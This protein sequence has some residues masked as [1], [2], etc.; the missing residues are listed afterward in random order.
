MG[1]LFI[2]LV[3]NIWHELHEGCPICFNDDGDW[4]RGIGGD[5]SLCSSS[6]LFDHSASRSLLLI[7]VVIVA[8]GIAWFGL[9]VQMTSQTGVWTPSASRKVVFFVIWLYFGAKKSTLCTTLGCIFKAH[10]MDFAG[11]GLHKSTPHTVQSRYSMASTKNQKLRISTRIYYLGCISTI[12]W[13]YTRF[14][15]PC[16]QPCRP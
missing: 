3:I 4:G 13:R 7:V 8:Y 2:L 5:Q 16:V 10:T 12:M 15:Q 6:S 9:V 1:V 14:I 11:I